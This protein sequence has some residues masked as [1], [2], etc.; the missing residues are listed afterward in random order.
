MRPSA[1]GRAEAALFISLFLCRY[2]LVS[3]RILPRALQVLNIPV[4]LAEQPDSMV[5]CLLVPKPCFPALKTCKQSHCS[6]VMGCP[7]RH[8]IS[9]SGSW[10]MLPK[11]SLY[12]LNVLNCAA[13]SRGAGSRLASSSWP[14]AGDLLAL[15]CFP[16][17]SPLCKYLSF[18]LNLT[19]LFPSVLCHY[20]SAFLPGI[21]SDH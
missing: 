9:N 19:K 2:G 13:L 8:R 18:F 12:A 3:H 17:W 6:R 4:S 21:T 7:V 20:S 10:Q 5:N 1:G 15:V 16:L 14:V 11:K